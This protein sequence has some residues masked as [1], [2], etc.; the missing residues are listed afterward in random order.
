MDKE[1]LESYWEIL[2]DTEELLTG[3]FRKPDRAKPDFSAL[4]RQ[5]TGKMRSPSDS[6]E[7][8]VSDFNLGE[9]G[10]FG[11]S[12]VSARRLQ[13]ESGLEPERALIRIACEVSECRKC[14]LAEGRTKTVPGE[15]VVN[16][17]VLIIGEGPGAEEDKTGEPFVGRAGKYLDKWLEAIGLSRTTN[18]F[19][20]NIVKCRPPGNRDPKPEEMEACFP[21]LLR[22]I[23]ILKPKAILTVGRISSQVLTGREEGIGKLRGET[24]SFQGIPLIPTYHPSGVL[25]SQATL[26]APVWEDLKRLKNL[27]EALGNSLENG[28]AQTP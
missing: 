14:G 23:K 28:K 26:R 21:Y 20:G 11:K 3:G 22:Q 7:K 25:R 18:C 8:L 17:L 9:K 24:Y 2:K 16:P 6:G 10:G 13:P 12:P 1:N 4:A 27:L 15:G 5:R 19:I